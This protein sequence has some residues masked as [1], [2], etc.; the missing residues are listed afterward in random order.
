M[1]DMTP[2]EEKTQERKKTGRS[3]SKASRSKSRPRNVAFNFSKLDDTGDFVDDKKKKI[4]HK[5]KDDKVK[6]KAETNSK[7]KLKKKK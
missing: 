3:K 1:A 4:V 6:P 7:L 5:S 2:P